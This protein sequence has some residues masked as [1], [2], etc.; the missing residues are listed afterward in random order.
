M[1]D[2]NKLITDYIEKHKAPSKDIFTGK[3]ITDDLLDRWGFSLEK[4]EGACA[5]IIPVK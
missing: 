3:N 2:F 4:A 1:S 5:R